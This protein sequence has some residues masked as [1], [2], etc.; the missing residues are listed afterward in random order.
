MK[1]TPRPALSGLSIGY[2]PRHFTVHRP[3]TKANGALRTLH[4]VDLVEVSVV[5][6]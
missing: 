5:D 6:S 2:R 4:D 1:T 3:G